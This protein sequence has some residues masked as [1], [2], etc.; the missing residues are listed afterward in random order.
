[1][2]PIQLYT[3]QTPNGHKA[4]IML[5]ETGLPYEVR[6]VD[7]ERGDQKEA[8]FLAL[9]PNNKIPVIVDPEAGRTVVESGAI[10]HYLAE[11]SGRFLPA[12][13][14][15]RT[16]TLAWTL[17]QAAHIGPT[18]GQLWNFKVFAAE[19]IPSVI[20]RFEAESARVFRVLDGQLGRHA[21]IVGEAYGIADVM[22][23]PWIH[24]AVTRLG[25]ALDANP[26]LARW[27]AAVAARPAVQRGL[28]VPALADQAH[29]A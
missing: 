15:E 8:A 7:I 21:H 1:M 14:R 23:W 2:I 12:G 3:Y 26:H 28:A 10:L 27:Y 19:K 17:F 25:L 18:L 9:N 16:D 4:S 22:T 11:R 6:L 20:G 24:A 13:E 29:A 5:E